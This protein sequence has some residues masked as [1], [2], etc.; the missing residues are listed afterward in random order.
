[1]LTASES[2]IYERFGYGIATWRLG[3]TAS[4]PHV[5]F[6]DTTSS[7]S[8]RFLARPEAETLLPPLYDRMRLARP[9]MVSR[10]DF[11]WPSVFWG[12]LSGPE[13][14]FFVA[15]HTGDD[16]T[17]DGYVAYEV[18]GGWEGGIPDRRLLLWDFQ[19]L[20]P[21]ARA[22]LWQFVFGVD[23]IGTIAATNLPIDEPLRHLV[24]ESRR[25][26]VDFI[27][28]GLWLAPIDSARLLA[29]RRYAA[30]GRIVIE[31]HDINGDKSTLALEAGDDDAQCEASS[32]APEIVC[33]TSMLGACLLGG[34]R[35]SE[36]A[37]AGLV[38]ERAS[39][40]LA[41]ADAMFASTPQ[42]AMLSY[43]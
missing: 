19:A 42:P 2:V 4:R 23:L 36:L 21:E 26:R 28:D 8:L 14:A 40:A 18:S 7:G 13:K 43:F 34:N 41:R 11:W 9:G 35:F 22:A 29:A 37:Q 25:I 30:P 27:N 1:M 20:T 16:G 3:L 32:S 15:V 10:P 31:V 24:V 39:G 17:D 5:R 38:E 6:R 12:Q 33:N